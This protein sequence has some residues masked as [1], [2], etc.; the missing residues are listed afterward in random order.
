LL[1]QVSRRF[2]PFDCASHILGRFALSVGHGGPKPLRGKALHAKICA[3]PTAF[4]PLRR[5]S[6]APGIQP[7]L[8]R[9]TAFDLPRLV[10]HAGKTEV[11]YAGPRPYDLILVRVPRAPKYLRGHLFSPPQRSCDSS[12]RN[13][14][15]TQRCADSEYR[16]PLGTGCRR[17]SE[18]RPLKAL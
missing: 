16:A 9:S 18:Y 6:H 4:Q 10:V 11:S 1:Q 2:S 12:Q 13:P 15:V 17:V 14:P 7:A 3:P 8:G 5:L